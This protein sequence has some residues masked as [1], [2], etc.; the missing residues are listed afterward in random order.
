MSLVRFAETPR[1]VSGAR[2]LRT[3]IRRHNLQQFGVDVDG[4]QDPELDGRTLCAFDA[5]RVLV[6]TIDVHWGGDADMPDK[7]LTTFRA[8]E[9]TRG[10]E[11][12]SIVVLD[13]PMIHP[14]FKN[15]PIGLELKEGAAR[16]ALRSGARFVFSS[17]VPGEVAVHEALGF[18]VCGRRWAGMP[19]EEHVP[20]L[21][22]LA[23]IAL[24]KRVRSPLVALAESK[25]MGST[26]RAVLPARGD[27]VAEELDPGAVWRI[28]FRLV[29]DARQSGAEFLSDIEKTE[30]G[31]LF[32]GA[33]VHTFP[34]G[35]FII[36]QRDRG[37]DLFLLLQGDV[38]AKRDTAVLGYASP[39]DVVGEMGFL[40][41]AERKADVVAMTN[42]RALRISARHLDQL[43]Q[44][45][46]ALAAKLSLAI[47][48]ALCRKLE[49][50]NATL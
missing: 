45:D 18:V 42:V 38:V 6:G 29:R 27:D 48:R 3:L 9:V 49:R 10:A 46:M 8:E 16:F 23:D 40:R 11:R 22:D 44:R 32:R 36:R 26:E 1:D 28:L 13:E 25:N 35:D 2:K 39:G 43:M 4:A 5:H 21:L 15:E 20:V 50:T 30:L 14:D 24:L 47:S 7:K 34:Q 41:E 17:S 33:H 12:E 31:E 19:T 37:R